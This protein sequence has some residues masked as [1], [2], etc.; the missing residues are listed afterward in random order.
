MMSRDQPLQLEWWQERTTFWLC[1]LSG[2]ISN[3]N[4]APPSSNPRSRSALSSFSNTSGEDG[5]WVV[6]GG[7]NNAEG[8]SS[9]AK[10]ESMS[11]DRMRTNVVRMAG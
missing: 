2:T 4:I 11:F 9:T 8:A 7:S 3:R 6:P 1:S 5:L 10:K